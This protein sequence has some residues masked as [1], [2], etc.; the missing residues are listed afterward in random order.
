[1]KL[2]PA[3]A[4]PRPYAQTARAE[5][6]RRT[7]ERILEAFLARLMGQWFDEITLDCVAADAGVTVQTVVRRFG[8]KEGL[9][10]G[11]VDVLAAQI[12]ANRATPAG[13]ID[14]AV[15]VLYADYERTG[16]AV[17]RLVA[18]E[19]RQPVIKPF[20]DIGR[21][22]HRQ[23]L[24]RAFAPSLEPLSPGD[25]ERALDALYVVT[26]VH[27]W[28]L[29]R[30]DFGRSLPAARSITRSLIAATIHQFTQHTSE[31]DRS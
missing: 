8:G 22:C 10:A 14:A 18:I 2:K 24:A 12:N 13:D 23:W 11:A 30:R 26:D 20:T 1:M 6:A 4:R 7:G 27:A 15:R 3:T 31:G 21:G 17:V 28:K 16:G 5:S 19:S 9:L 29:L 25:R